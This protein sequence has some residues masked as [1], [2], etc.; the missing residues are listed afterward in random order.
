MS[1]EK[2]P[3]TSWRVVAFIH[4]DVEKSVLYRQ[5]IASDYLL[6]TIE[7]GIAR[8]ANIF[9]IRGFREGEGKK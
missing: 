9:S 8:G 3:C 1:P 2:K 5:N 6:K 4:P 7:E